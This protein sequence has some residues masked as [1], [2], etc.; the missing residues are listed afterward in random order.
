MAE[1]VMKTKIY[2]AGMLGIAFLLYACGDGSVTGTGPENP[3]EN[4]DP[5]PIAETNTLTP[6][7]GGDGQF[8]VVEIDGVPFYRASTPSQFIYFNA[9]T[10]VENRTVYVKIYY[11]DNG[12]GTFTLQYNSTLDNYSSASAV[13]GANLEDT[14]GVRVAVFELEN[15]DFR[16]AQNLEADLRV[17][18]NTGEQ[19]H[20]FLA[21]LSFEFPDDMLTPAPTFDM[22]S[23]IV[24]TTVFHWYVP[25]GGQL[26]GPWRPIEGRENWTGE[27]EWWKSQ[28]KQIMAAN[29]DVLWV[30]LIPSMEN[31]RVNLFRALYEMRLEG[32]DVPRVAPFLDPLITW[33]E[34]P[35]IDLATG[36]GKDE[37]A[38]Q[39]IR[40]FNQYFDATPDEFAEDYLAKTDGRINLDTWHIHLNTD[41]FESMTRGDL[42][43]RLKAEFSSD[44]PSFNNGIYMITTAISPTFS[45]TDER[46]IQFEVN[47]YFVEAAH[48]G[49]KT[50]QLK[51]GYWDQNVRTPGDFMPRDGGTPYA[52]AWQQ[53]DNSIDRIYIESWNEY[54][55][56]T[57]IYAANTGAPDIHPGSN[58]TN[59]DTWSNSDDPYEY[60][61]T[62]ARGAA[63]FND[64]PEHN[65]IILEHTLPDTIKAGETVYVSVTV[66]N[67][68]DASWTGQ[69]GYQFIQMDGNATFSVPISIN[70]TID[71]IS[72]YGGI[73]RGRPITFTLALT[74]PQSPGD[75]STRWGMMQEG[76]GSFGEDFTKSIY[77]KEK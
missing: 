11:R 13:S 23:R 2:V 77:V 42:E 28:I 69:D 5:M 29:I 47:D 66:R 58:N 16:S 36:A 19:M 62:T 12:I 39:Y 33:Y 3:D 15:A 40:F 1:F 65:A 52:D 17:F 38:A 75:Y 55:E 57:G 54:D 53:V 35:N 4:P 31:V 6:V 41:N 59:T 45:F 30:H 34:Q 24:S 10:K 14:K 76:I 44:Y 20:I 8:E 27:P 51:G 32:Y 25:N 21:F 22:K 37:W 67:T 60:I 72:V 9:N 18:S 56:G 61:K 48:N 73:F 63:A 46:T 49:I 26:T 68:G 7:S 70:D 71:E 50:V 64:T 74:A 43:S